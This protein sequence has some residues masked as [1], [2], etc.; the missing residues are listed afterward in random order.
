MPSPVRVVGRVLPRLLLGAA[1]AAAAL[2]AMFYALDR[3]YYGVFATVPEAVG[4]GTQSLLARVVLALALVVPVLVVVA[5]LAATVAALTGKGGR[6]GR[7]LRAATG[8]RRVRAV[9]AALVTGAALAGI[10]AGLAPTLG[11]VT[12][13]V[14]GVLLT[15]LCYRPAYLLLKPGS[16]GNLLV[17]AVV[18]LAV[19]GVG[20]VVVGAADREARELRA[21]G[22]PGP[23]SALLGVPPRQV[24]AVDVRAGRGAP[25]AD[26]RTLVLLGAASG[27][28]TLYDCA[29]QATFSMPVGQVV[30][31][32]AAGGSAVATC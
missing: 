2:Y 21:S 24:T 5:A 4:A 3:R 6:T 23:V 32:R 30:L 15:L 10:V 28:F 16:A 31:A 13:V 8:D 18:A 7:F 25:V 19:L 26:G 29:R 17:P 22:R 11:A 27:S 20:G 1:L 12:V 9:V 14:I